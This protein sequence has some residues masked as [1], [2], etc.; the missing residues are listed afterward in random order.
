[1][2]TIV[3]RGDLN[4][5]FRKLSRYQSKVSHYNDLVERYRSAIVR[6]FENKN[7]KQHTDLDGQVWQKR[8]GTSVSYREDA[9]RALLR[10]KHIKPSVVFKTREIVEVDEDAVIKLLKA[11]A[12][13]VEEYETVVIRQTHKPFVVKLPTRRSDSQKAAESR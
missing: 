3:S 2:Q 1:M 13:T 4:Q 9:L 12:I 11:Q 6:Y 5:A 10:R 8:Q 7:I